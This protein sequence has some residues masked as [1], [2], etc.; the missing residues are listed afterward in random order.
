MIDESAHNF[1]ECLDCKR[2]LADVVV[3]K[4]SNEISLN[5]IAICPFCSGQSEEVKVT[6][7]VHLGSV[8]GT[9]LKKYESSH[10]KVVIQ[11]SKEG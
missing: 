2:R 4:E 1:L 10:G 7:F 6:G 5:Y 9:R 8:E 11:L 3:T